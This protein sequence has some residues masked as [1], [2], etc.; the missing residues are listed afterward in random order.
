MPFY[1]IIASVIGDD[2]GP[3]VI[4]SNTGAIL[5]TGVTKQ[6]LLDGFTFDVPVG[7]TSV[8]IEN[9]PSNTICTEN[10][11]ATFQIPREGTWE[12]E[13][14]NV[15]T[16]SDHYGVILAP[17]VTPVE[18]FVAEDITG[19]YAGVVSGTTSTWL[20]KGT[21]EDIVGTT[22]N[23]GGTLIITGVNTNT[24]TVVEN[25]AILQVGYDL[26]SY[27]GQTGTNTNI[28]AGG[29]VNV[30]GAND[31]PG[32]RAIGNLTNA[33]DL[34]FEGPDRCGEGTFRLIGTINNT[35]LITVKDNAKLVLGTAAV[36]SSVVG[37][38][39][40]ED[41][42]TVD[43]TTATIP[44]SQTVKVNGC[45]KCN[46][47]GEL[48]GAL[49]FSQNHSIGGTIEIETDSCVKVNPGSSATFGGIMTGSAPLRLSNGLENTGSAAPNGT[50]NI[51]GNTNTYS[52]TITAS[53]VNLRPSANGIANA[54]R[55]VLENG[56]SLRTSTAGVAQNIKSVATDDPETDWTGDGVQNQLTAN[57]ITTFAGRIIGNGTSTHFVNVAGGSENQ[58][59]VTNEN[60]SNSVLFAKDGAIINL[61]GK[62]TGGSSGGNIQATNGGR[63]GAGKS[64]TSSA[65]GMNLSTGGE[66]DVQAIS[67]T[68]AGFMTLTSAQFVLPAGSTTFPIN[69]LHPMQPGTYPILRVVA[70]TGVGYGKIPT[71]VINNTGLTPTYSWDTVTRTL[72]MTLA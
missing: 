38:T 2:A 44:N 69:L 29:I 68:Q 13:K 42:A 65:L 14:A 61:E 33:G 34:T 39:L 67:P 59:T 53:N 22:Y 43:V 37:T 50:F 16:I 24:A 54:F 51:N 45:G 58:L 12:M 57:G 47:I 26:D 41:G 5:A 15:E 52:G 60:N 35:G 17:F 7:V 32:R 6:Q 21:A 70:G 18:T 20:I 8:T 71:T 30:V 3:F 72:S 62:L 27:T 56:A 10:P 64:I 25:G 36:Y 48:E 1:K 11:V 55:V 31:D 66:F 9:A 28:N 46:D 23:P 49:Y 40:I 63:V 4:K 19:I